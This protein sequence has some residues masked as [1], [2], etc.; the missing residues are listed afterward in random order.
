VDGPEHD[1]HDLRWGLYDLEL[2]RYGDLGQGW[3][4]DPR[5]VGGVSEHFL[6]AFS[7]VSSV[8]HRDEAVRPIPGH[9]IQAGTDKLGRLHVDERPELEDEVWRCSE[10]IHPVPLK[11]PLL[12]RERLFQRPF[13][14]AGR[15]GR[16]HPVAGYDERVPTSK[17]LLDHI[18]DREA[19]YPDRVY[20]TQPLGGGAVRDYTWGQALD[21][22]RRMA[23]HLRSLGLAPG[24][25]IAILS[26]NCAHFFMAE[27]AIWMAGYT[28]VAIFPT[29]TADTIRF[30]LAH[31]EAKVLL[32]GKLDGW[33]AQSVGVS[34]DVRQIRWPLAPPTATAGESW[35]DIV[36]RTPALDGRPSRAGTDLAMLIYTSGS[37]GEPKGVMH[38][39]DGVTR[40]ITGILAALG[41]R[42]DDRMLSYL[43]LAHV[44]ERALV[45]CGS[46]VTGMHV[47]FAESLD[48]FIADLRRARPTLFVSVPRLWIKFQDGV[49][50]KLPPKKLGR[51]LRIPIVRGLIR[52]KVLAGLGL[53]HVRLA[54]SSSAP[55]PAELIAWYRSLGLVMLEGYGMTEDF[56]HSHF[57]SPDRSAHGYVGAPYPGV[58][59]KLSS[60]GEVLVKSPGR[61]VGYFKRPDLDAECFTE[62]GYFRTGD[63]G[64]RRED[65]L[66]KLTGRVK[67]LF[68][69]GK[70]K[71]VAPAPIENK[72]NEHPLVELSCVSGVGQPAAYALVQLAENVSKDLG[73]AAVRARV[74]TEL[75]AWLA[76]VNATLSPY[77]QLQMIVIAPE[78]WTIENGQLTP[79][80]KLKRARIEA[81][82]EP[83]LTDWYQRGARVVWGA[84]PS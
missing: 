58:D 11:V 32:V 57:S 83:Q 41:V 78:P 30:I 74:E 50:T 45:L 80:M 15:P 62:D 8:E 70:G 56:G 14:E 7:I 25:R 6:Q 55:M 2:K 69:T 44:F 48:T 53:E 40:A 54:G 21:E 66:L 47:F 60:E 52:K 46:F 67:E 29:E 3:I 4:T 81:A 9:A 26:K 77:E 64:E 24:D 36:A 65:G 71:Y 59:V 51:L 34:A 39:F 61:M 75:G 1:A 68:K 42:E 12:G 31:S 28:T 35:D 17:L 16:N 72:L 43:P 19:R 23:T 13:V 63:K 79:T 37:T 33:P 10:A 22:A 84:R 82:V 73:D 38:S 18:Y 76:T 20:L 27:I 5:L 49:H